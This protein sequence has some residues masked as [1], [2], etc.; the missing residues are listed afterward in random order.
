[1]DW[2]GTRWSGGMPQDEC[3]NGMQLGPAPAPLQTSECTSFGRKTCSQAITCKKL[4]STQAKKRSKAIPILWCGQKLLHGVSAQPRAPRWRLHP[5]LDSR[6]NRGGSGTKE[7]QPCP[8]WSGPCRTP[9]SKPLRKYHACCSAS[10]LYAQRFRC[11]SRT[12]PLSRC[13]HPQYSDFPA[14]CGSACQW[15]LKGEILVQRHKQSCRVFGWQLKN[16]LIWRAGALFGSIF[17]C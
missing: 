1:M 3:C 6:H 5:S 9:I 13:I 16:K 15:W 7:W 2:H 4:P 11:W 8:Q 12:I 14:R 17:I 10:P